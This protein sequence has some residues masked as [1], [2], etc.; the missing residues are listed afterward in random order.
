MVNAAHLAAVGLASGLVR[1]SLV[2][3]GQDTQLTFRDGSTLVL[4]GVTRLDAV[5]SDTGAG[6]P[7]IGREIGDDGEGAHCRRHGGEGM[8]RVGE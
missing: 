3:C 1:A 4:K 8:D 6:T 7:P 5:L 2:N